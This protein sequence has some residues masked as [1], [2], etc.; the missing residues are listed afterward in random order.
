MLTGHEYTN[1]RHA[2]QRYYGNL[3][4]PP[5]YNDYVCYERLWE[6]YILNAAMILRAV[7]GITR[8]G[9]IAMESVPGTNV[10]P[11]PNYIFYNTNLPINNQNNQD[12]YLRNIFNGAHLNPGLYHAGLSKQ[13]CLDGLL[14]QND[15]TG[16]QRPIILFDLLPTHGI[17]LQTNHRRSL[18]K[19]ALPAIPT[20]IQ[21]KLNFVY[22]NLL[23]PLG[24]NW[25]NIHLK[26]ACPPTTIDPP[27]VIPGVIGGFSPGIFIHPDT[28]NT[29]GGGI[30]PNPNDLRDNIL[31]HGF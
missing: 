20:Q 30:A 24:L 19:G 10:H 9:L 8:L 13:Q 31:N 26:F 16:T 2:F 15:I 4:L 1:F 11:A 12:S 6:D 18:R 5:T 25:G 22:N 21:N 17:S 28:I 14:H 3:P 23:L 29:I 7:P 27:S